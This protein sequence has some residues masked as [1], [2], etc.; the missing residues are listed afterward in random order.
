MVILD[1]IPTLDPNPSTT[2]SQSGCLP[3]SDK[4]PLFICKERNKVRATSSEQKE[5][6]MPMACPTGVLLLRL[7]LLF[8]GIRCKTSPLSRLASFAP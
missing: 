2:E 5:K 3:Y 6:T 8:H 7:I 1:R 4:H